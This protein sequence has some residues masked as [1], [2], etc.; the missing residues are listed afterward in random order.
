MVR[1]YFLMN[2]SEQNTRGQSSMGSVRVITGSAVVS[3]INHRWVQDQEIRYNMSNQISMELEINPRN[4]QGLVLGASFLI[5]FLFRITY[6]DFVGVE[7]WMVVIRIRISLAPNQESIS[8]GTTGNNDYKYIIIIFWWILQ[9][10]R[11]EIH[12][13]CCQLSP[14]ACLYHLD[15]GI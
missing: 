5:L 8:I 7:W 3:T 15:M 4:R 6:C 9:W 14:P 1:N 10:I 2:S 12:Q 13:T 11:N